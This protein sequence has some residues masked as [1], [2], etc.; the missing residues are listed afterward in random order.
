MA[1]CAIR[2][3][4]GA[5]IHAG[6]RIHVERVRELKEYGSGAFVA[7]ERKQVGSA[8]GRGRGVALFADLLLHGFREVVVVAD[9]ALIV[10][11]PFENYRTL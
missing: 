6:F 10:A 5:G 4:T 2:A 8:G 9:F 3:E 11:W 7:R 1:E